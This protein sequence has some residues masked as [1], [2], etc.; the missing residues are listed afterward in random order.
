MTPAPYKKIA[1]FLS[2]TFAFS[3]IFYFLIIF[4]GTPGDFPIIGLMWCPGIAAIITQLVFHRSLRGLGWKPG[5]FK[6]LLVAY[7]LPVAVGLISYTIIWLTGLGRFAPAEMMDQMVG[8]AEAENLSLTPFFVDYVLQMATLGVLFSL[9]SALGEEIG[10]RGLLVPELARKLPF[11]KTALISGAIWVVWHLPVILLGGYRNEG[12][13]VWFGLICFC[14]LAVGV[15]FPLAW[16]RLK[17]GS[18]WPAAL[19]HASHNLFI[20]GIF[21]PLTQDTG[22]TPY[23]YDE[24]GIAL[25]LAMIGVAYIYWRERGKVEAVEPHTEQVAAV[26]GVGA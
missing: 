19:L 25:A 5:R 26:P 7:L 12:A 13:P 3:L 23:V 22:P 10:W 6:Y 2:I 11:T 17:S 16:L 24:F 14:C 20:Q 8:S 15:S 4:A 9:M 21:T 1:V 18:L